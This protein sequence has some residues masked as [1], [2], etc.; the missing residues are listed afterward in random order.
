MKQQGG[1]Y[2]H[3][4]CGNSKAIKTTRRRG[5][6]LSANHFRRV[7]PDEIKSAVH[8]S[9]FVSDVLVQLGQSGGGWEVEGELL[10][11]CLCIGGVLNNAQ[12]SGLLRC[13]VNLKI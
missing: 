1:S 10:R 3:I 8:I 13:I 7:S 4:N 9:S 5:N 11:D 12:H 2:D 6:K